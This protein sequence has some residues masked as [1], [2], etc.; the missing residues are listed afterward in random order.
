MAL[1]FEWLSRVPGFRAKARLVAGKL[2]PDVQF[3]RAWSPLARRGRVGLAAAYA[4]RILWLAWH[5]IPGFIAWL[6]A[7][8]S[9]H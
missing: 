5:A 6:R 2:V 7:R 3:M 8:R 1:G 9:A 4:F